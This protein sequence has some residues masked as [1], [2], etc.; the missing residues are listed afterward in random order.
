MELLFFYFL[1][2]LS[3]V[4]VWLIFAGVGD[5]KKSKAV[6]DVSQGKTTRPHRLVPTAVDQTDTPSMPLSNEGIQ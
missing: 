1:G 5:L 6:R 2:A 4:G 3:A